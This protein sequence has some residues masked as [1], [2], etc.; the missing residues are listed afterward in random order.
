MAEVR[1]MQGAVLRRP[2][3]MAEVRK[4]QGAVLRRPP[5]QGLFLQSYCISTIHGGQMAEVQILHRYMDVT[6]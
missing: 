2:P 1:K 5:W 4:M 6:Y 3:W